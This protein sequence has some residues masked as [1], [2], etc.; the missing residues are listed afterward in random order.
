MAQ[1]TP[2][3]YEARWK[4][5][6]ELINKKGLTRSALEQVKEISAIAKK[7]KQEAQFIKSLVY[8]ADL[9][10]DL[11][12]EGDTEGIGLLLK[13]LKEAKSPAKQL[14]HSI[15]ATE[16]YH[17]YQENRWE[18][19]DRTPTSSFNEL[20]LE[21]W[22]LND[23][24]RVIAA[25]YLASLEDPAL[26]QRTSLD[27]YAPL[28]SNGNSRTL[29]PTL[30]D[31][32]ANQALDYF[33]NDE[34]DV[35]T[36]STAFEIDDPRVFAPAGSFITKDFKTTDS[37][38]LYYR[39]IQIYQELLRFHLQDKEPSALLDADLQRLMFMHRVSV[40]PEKDDRF[41][42]AL[43]QFYHSFPKHPLGALA[44]F[45]AINNKLE[46]ARSFNPELHPPSRQFELTELAEQLNVLAKAFPETAAG[47]LAANSLKELNGL[48]L[49]GETEL[50][51]IPGKPFLARVSYKNIS[52]IYYRIIRLDP[53]DPT[54]RRDQKYWENLV[55][56]Q[57]LTDTSIVVPDAGD[58]RLHSAE[59]AVGALPVGRF[60]MLMG[61]TPDFRVSDPLAVQYFHVSNIS[62][63]HQ[64]Q[65]YF[66]LHRDSGNPLSG[67]SIKVIETRYDQRTASQRYGV[68][69]TA[70]AN[71]DGLAR[72]ELP[73]KMNGSYMLDITWG[74]DRLFTNEVNYHYNNNY[75]Q[76][77]HPFN[78]LIFTDRSI[79]RPGQL[80]Y[81]KG[82]LI[83]RDPEGRNNT[84]MPNME[85]SF[86]L[87]D[88]NGERLSTL[89]L[90]SNAFGSVKGE[91]RIP[92]NRLT[93]GYSIRG[94][95]EQDMAGFQ[96]EEYKRPGFSVEFEPLRTEHRLG[97]TVTIT[98]SVEGYAGNSMNNADI[99]YRVV[100]K[101]RFPFWRGYYDFPERG[102]AAEITHGTLKTDE[103]GKFAIAFKATPDRSVDKKT[104]P[105]FEYQ[106]IVDATDNSGETRSGEKLVSI[107]YSSLDLA[108]AGEDSYK[109][110]LDS[111]VIRLRNLEGE[112]LSANITVSIYSINTPSRLLKERM[113]KKPDT[114]LI[115]YADFIRDFPHDEYGDEGNQAKWGNKEKLVSV[116]KPMKDGEGLSF[117]T[118]LPGWYRIEL[119][120]K[121]KYGEPVSIEKVVAI[122]DTKKIGSNDPAYTIVPDKA[123][124]IDPGN[125]AVLTFGTAADDVTMI[126]SVYQDDK[127]DSYTLIR[128][129]KRMSSIAIPVTEKNRGGIAINHAFVKHNRFYN[130]TQVVNVPWSNKELEISTETWRDKLLPGS[131]ETWKVKI[132]G[133]KSEKIAAE[134]LTSM[135]DASLDQFNPHSWDRPMLFRTIYPRAWEAG[136]NF[137][138][139]HTEN[140]PAF[141]EYKEVPPKTYDAFIWKEERINARTVLMSL[142]MRADNEMSAPPAAPMADSSTVFNEVVLSGYGKNKSEENSAPKPAEPVTP[143]KNFTETAFFFPQLQTDAEGNIEFTFTMPESLTRWKWM[144]LAHSK[145]LAMGSIVRN[146]ITQKDL[147][148]QPNMPRFLREGDM[149]SLTARISN[150][151]AN[152]MT[153]QAEL[154]LIDPETNTPVDGLFKNVFPIQHF[155]IER[156]QTSSVQFQVEVPANYTKP[157]QY[158]V[159]ARS[160]NNSDGEENIIPVLTTRM[161]VTES[162][163]LLMKGDGNK[164]FIFTKLLND[165]SNSL[166]HYRLSVEYSTNPAWYA[167]LALPYLMEFP[168]EC[169]EQTFSRF[170]ANALAAQVA[171][172]SPA[173][174]MMFENWRTK[175]SS[176]LISNLLKNQELKQLLIEQ[177]PWVLE[178]KTASQ[179]RRNIAML[180][181]M[182]KLSAE[183][184]KNLQ[185]LKQ[186]QH[187]DG[188]FPWFKGGPDDRYI[189]QYILTGIGRLQYLQAVPED[190]KTVLEDIRTDALDYLDNEIRI[191]YDRL[192]NTKADLSKQQTGYFELQYLFMRSYFK[193]P[194]PDKSRK[195]Y[196]YYLG[197]AKLFWLK[198]GLYG[199]AMTAL[200]ALR[201]GDKTT[202][203]AILR[204]LRENAIINESL[205][206][207]WKENTRGY[208]WYESPVE[209]QSLLIEAF[210]EILS[211]NSAVENMKLW[212]LNQKRVQDWAS[213]RAT[214][215]AVFALVRKGN[216][217]LSATPTAT[218][219]LGTTSFSP[220]TTESGTGYFKE[221]V[222]G[223]KVNSGMGKVNVDVK[224]SGSGGI[225]WG[226]VHWQYFEQME[227]ITASSSP[228][229]ITKQ[230]F[231]ER[232]SDAG[233]VLSELKEGQSLKVGDKLKVRVMLRADRDMEYMHMKDMRASG[234]EP[235]NVISSYKWQGGLGYYESTRDASTDFFFDWLP[236]GNWSFEYPLFVTHNGQFSA[237]I[238]T[239]Q[240]MYAPEFN[241]HSE[242]RKIAVNTQE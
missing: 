66:V 142:S 158:R 132:K 93:G 229:T 207:Y 129:N 106:V 100:R 176:A 50:V 204:S 107:G 121:D 92:E 199:Q 65:R 237:G 193:N 157:L 145:D 138:A 7:E 16:Y 215:D 91:F 26:L 13:E 18:L 136:N 232:N 102:E 202:A 111:I 192:V 211:D 203:T 24:H 99:S 137:S 184:R 74:E 156:A 238:C 122:H 112:A 183:L 152:S 70:S 172:G 44:A 49:S 34:R 130:I 78:A 63:I 9:G 41:N 11:S 186:M 79:Y 75:Q 191:N 174:R 240:S 181:E 155:T 218:I 149:I 140:K 87:Y 14:L 62:Y 86:S 73:E 81:F 151:T 139:I 185:K 30:Y 37:S 4:T 124:T 214:A 123:V 119:K 144:M 35:K 33:V 76:P 171:S 134:L 222:D 120:A 227:K 89:T 5:I 108:I 103:K 196:D 147:M 223:A 69:A 6:D 194:L 101:M 71:K 104:L 200:I 85:T 209:T 25:H 154:Q 56:L 58:L 31:L 170:Y 177:T 201:S 20:D 173:I 168:Y 68:L 133:L 190:A 239:L 224:G 228:V 116:T 220:S 195:A 42:T 110:A 117:K 27:N 126:R 169:A 198:Q 95:H 80:V 45:H 51:N 163:P 57:S 128:L 17:Y 39:A 105:V 52:R 146:V 180:F 28:I 235:V 230:F 179:Q 83:H 206:M 60:A 22:S 67:A 94:E 208:R 54:L 23:F 36:P 109:D 10:I 113:W 53:D 216:N 166:S 72:L 210:D 48:E 178:A 160:G 115:P 135:Y 165:R 148:V 46:R 143:R 187:E 61:T 77:Q 175:D 1:K 84:V 118:L 150:M 97:D 2:T 231:I 225:S 131:K 98:G 219:K 38:S 43:E 15:L 242:G 29:R 153:G 161:L 82:L 127:D 226:A 167:V 197:Q 32:L 3:D 212:L 221:M 217:W 162:M 96:V 141:D 59:I 213:T 236:K 205:G 164:D 159:I 241:A 234:T 182:Q 8:R 55:S 19:Y 47:I 64:D 188:S 125:T 88:A 189:T 90:K 21:S 12:E 233:P 114:T 40:E